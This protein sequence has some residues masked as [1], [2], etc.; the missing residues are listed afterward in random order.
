LWWAAAACSDGAP[1]NAVSKNPA[2]RYSLERPTDSL[3]QPAAL[4]ESFRRGVS[5]TTFVSELE[6]RSAKPQYGKFLDDIVE[7]GATDL[8]LVVR[9]SQVN[10]QAV[11]IA[12]SARDS[13]D[14]GVLAWMMD[15]ANTRG[16]RV[17]LMPLL[18]VESQPGSAGR[19]KIAPESWNR[20]WWSYHRFVMYYARIAGAH[21]ADVFTLGCELAGAESQAERWRAL[22]TDVRKVYRGK[23]SYVANIDHVESVTFWDAVD[24][25]VVSGLQDGLQTASASDDQIRQALMTRARKLR[26]W[27]LAQG[28]R[29]VFTDLGQSTPLPAPLA[30]PAAMAELRRQRALFEVWQDD[31]RLEGVFA[32]SWLA[33]GTPKQF[34]VVRSKHSA[35]VLRHWYRASRVAA[36]G[37]VL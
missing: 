26:T 37:S 34:A 17:S 3:P 8:E 18:E 29:Y 6:A 36:Q 9:W 32:G 19:T 14:D 13:V 23:L 28:K 16:L 24:M 11:E 30:E 31:P 12:P 35:E 27:A 7:L 21:K 20:W 10:T 25:A 33:L 2:P 22:A 15:E 1:Q 5:L 4:P